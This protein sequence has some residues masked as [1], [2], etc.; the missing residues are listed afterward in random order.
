MKGWPGLVFLGLALAA[1]GATYS[2]SQVPDPFTMGT[3]GGGPGAPGGAPKGPGIDC[4]AEFQKL[5]AEMQKRGLAI[6]AASER[7]ASAK[8]AC[9]LLRR[10]T[11]A[12]GQMLAFLKKYTGPCGIP[13]EL[14]KQM[15]MGASK[16]GMMRDNVCKAASGQAAAPPPP[17]PSQGLSGTLSG[18]SGGGPNDNPSGGGVFDS[19]TGNVLRQ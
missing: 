1:M 9:V 8:D 13:G 5:N 2:H 10:Y 7:K 18:G 3:M 17:P 11:D 19:L 14:L 4:N 6:K 15:A 12:E 16:S